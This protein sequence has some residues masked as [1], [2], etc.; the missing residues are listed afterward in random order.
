ME[1]VLYVQVVMLRRKYLKTTEANKNKNDAKFKFQ[2]Q[3]A[4]SHCWFDLDFDIIGVNFSTREPDLYKKIFQR[5]YDTQGTNTFKIFEV[6][7]V[8]KI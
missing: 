8:W 6:K 5:H 4:I 3:S 1:Q 7:N 2:G